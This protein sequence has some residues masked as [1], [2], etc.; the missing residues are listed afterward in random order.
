[1]SE[2][3]ICSLISGSKIGNLSSG[4]SERGRGARR[5]VLPSEFLWD[6]NEVKRLL[7][8]I[9]KVSVISVSLPFSAVIPALRGLDSSF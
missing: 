7:C 8:S 2:T 9:A 4:M 1:M 5:T 3:A 6:G